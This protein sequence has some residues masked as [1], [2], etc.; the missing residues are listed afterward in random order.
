MAGHQE[1]LASVPLFSKL[2][3]KTLD[4]LDRIVVQ[5]EF[6]A[7]K[8]IVT[9]G[10]TGAGFFLIESGEVEVIH[11]STVLATLGKGGSFGEMAMLD[12]RPRVASV[13]A[14]QPT[15]CLVMTRWDFLAEVRSNPDIAVELLEQLSLIIRDLEKRLD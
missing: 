14:T 3:K 4:R 7:G 6:P 9:E 11:G 10:D 2:N 5:R 8:D 15:T 13:R 1:L 12:G